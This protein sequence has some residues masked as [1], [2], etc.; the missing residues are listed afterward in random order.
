[1]RILFAALTACLLVPMPAGYAHHSHANLDDTNIQQRTGVVT[2]YSWRMP[3]VFLE[4]RGPND[5]GELVNWSIE[6]LHPPGMVRWGWDQDSFVAGDRITWEGPMDVDPNRYYSGLYWAEKADGTRLYNNGSGQA[7][8]EPP[9]VPSTDFTGLWARDRRVG[10]TYTP[11]AN[12]PYNDRAM[13]LVA[14]F[15]ETQNPQ[16]DCEDP[17]PPKSTMLP[18]PVRISSPEDGVFILDY[19]LRD[20]QRVFRLDADVEPAAPSKTGQSRAW[21]DGDALVVETTNF[22]ADRWG[23][24][25]GVDSSEQKHLLERFT[26][27]EGGMTLRV[28][29]TLTDPVYFTEPVEIDYYMRKLADRDLVPAVCSVESARFF[30]EAGFE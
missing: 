30:I 11:P 15:D 9:A 18:Y 7:T 16:L 26:L 4:V 17:G 20:Q 29:M 3:H 10:F 13:A 27:I 2:K 5:L 6:L 25:T 14:D 19:E 8:A 28:E 1:M 23:S 22:V 12:W 24:H 21:M